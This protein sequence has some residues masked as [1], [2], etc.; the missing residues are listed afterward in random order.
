MNGAI[1][2]LADFLAKVAHLSPTEVVTAMNWKDR[3]QLGAPLDDART[4]ANLAELTIAAMAHADLA[5]V[6][7]CRLEPLKTIV[8]GWQGSPFAFAG[9]FMGASRHALGRQLGL[10]RATARWLWSPWWRLV[11][12]ADHVQALAK[13]GA[14]LGEF[15]EAHEAERAR[16]H[17]QAA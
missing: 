15:L 3:G 4:L 1:H 12:G 8:E 11:Q 6:G 5:G 14:C 10:D 17:K 2:T 9:E 13:L 7:G 16:R